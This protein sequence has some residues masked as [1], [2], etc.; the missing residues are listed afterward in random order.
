MYGMLSAQKRFLPFREA[1]CDVG[2]S[3]LPDVGR[4]SLRPEC[5]PLP[6]SPHLIPTIDTDLFRL[7]G[8]ATHG[9]RA[10]SA[11]ELDCPVLA[12]RRINEARLNHR[13]H[14]IAMI[15]EQCRIVIGFDGDGFPIDNALRDGWDSHRHHALCGAKQSGE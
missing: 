2:R 6:W 1:L 10:T 15:Q 11:D 5:F 4:L 9:Q 7:P 8:I 3:T 14:C 12:L 13:V